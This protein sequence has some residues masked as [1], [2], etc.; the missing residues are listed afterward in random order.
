MSIDTLQARLPE[1]SRKVLGFSSL[2]AASIGVIVAQLGMVSLMQGVGIGG[3]ASSL[4]CRSPFFWH[5]PMPWPTLKW[6]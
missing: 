4:H 3:G 2:F 1:P 5:W 6:H